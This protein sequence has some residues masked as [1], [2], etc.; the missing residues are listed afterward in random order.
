MTLR[1]L[2][3]QS[4]DLTPKNVEIVVQDFNFGEYSI[5]RAYKLGDKLM[6]QVEY[7]GDEKS[8]EELQTELDSLQNDYAALEKER[9]ELSRELESIGD[10]ATVKADKEELQRL[11]DA[12]NQIEQAVSSFATSADIRPTTNEA[13]NIDMLHEKYMELQNM[14]E[15]LDDEI[16]GLKVD[17]NALCDTIFRQEQTIARLEEQLAAK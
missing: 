14:A 15:S 1:Q 8:A 11:E 16:G 2:L 13:N 4:P 12:F 5:E 6:I 9:D 17:N 3:N 10:A 7:L